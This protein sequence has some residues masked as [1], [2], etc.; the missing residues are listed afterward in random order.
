MAGFWICLVIVSQEL[1]KPP[2]LNM[3]G[4]TIWP[5][6]EYA[7]VTQ[8]TEHAML[9]MIEYV[10]IY[11]KKQSPEYARILNVSDAVHSIRAL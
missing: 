4:F 3:P 10:D 7:R 8:G 11:L 5:G 1:D 9:N 6:C 2:V